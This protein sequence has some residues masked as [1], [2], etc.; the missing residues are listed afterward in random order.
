MV[1]RRTARFE[2]HFDHLT[3]PRR[4]EG[5]YPLVNIVVIAVCAVISGADDFVAIADWANLKKDW[6]AKF[7]DLSAG[8]PSHDRFNALFRALKP[9]EFEQCL[10]SWITALHEVTDGQVV[11][12]DGKTLRRSFDTASSKAAIH[13]VSAWATANSISL[14]QVVTD[15]KSN[16]ITA[17][18]KLLQILEISGSLVTI[19]AMG[20]QKEIA[21]QIVEAKADYVLAVKDNQPKL[22][23]AIRDFF[24]EHLE[25]DLQQVAHRRH[26]T[27]EKGHGRHDDRYYYLAKLP[28][29]FPLAE[30]WP[31]LKAIGLAV[32]VTEHMDG[33]T[34][35]DVRYYIT[36]RYL[37][38]KRFAEA[39]RGHW[40]IENSLHWQLDVTFGEDQSR[41][42]KGHADANFSLLRRA[43]LSLLKNN[44]SKKLGVKN[45]RLSAAWS[46][47]YRLQVLC[48]T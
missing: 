41:I 43:S 25:D 34:S 24:S 26:E 6:L 36:S 16:E 33:R 11:A 35:D 9:A 44:K 29:D 3:D 7:L 40:G 2:E 30:E 4:R 46:D 17:I 1:R 13:M 27:H 22:C 37:S 20:C 8:I 10:L 19:D 45:K 42:R 5:V 31:G 32:R 15:E 47:D 14:G 23:E 48:G 39:V 38:G 12:I 28:D 21:R 18:P